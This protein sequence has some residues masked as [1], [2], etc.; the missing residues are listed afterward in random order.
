MVI[1]AGGNAVA[2]R[3]SNSG[4][5]PFWGAA[6][7]YGVAALGFWIIVLVRRIGLP[8]GRALV[9]VAVYGVLSV[10]GSYALLYWGLLRATAGQAGALLGLAPLLTLVFAWLHG[11]ERFRWQGLL[12]TLIATA[13]VLVGVVGGFGGEA[14]M[15]SLLALIAGVGFLA[16]SNVVYKLFPPSDPVATN[17]VSLTIGTPF[18]VVLSLLV[19]EKWTLPTTR[20]TWLAYGYLVLIG[21]IGVFYLYLTVLSRWTASA[22]SYSFLLI[23]VA[24]VIVA[25]LVASERITLPFVA[26]GVLVLAGVWLGAI[27]KSPKTAELV[28]SEVPSRALC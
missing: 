22:T 21:T 7:R 16:E 23:P 19:G 17:A 26:G 27:R 25:A 13:G 28:C 5:P 18:L 24:T 9:G 2:V 1:F 11:V 12:G 6:L 20:N 15:P 4:L 3:F 10:G 14:H 8:R